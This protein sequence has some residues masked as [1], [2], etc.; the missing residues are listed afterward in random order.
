MTLDD[1][2]HRFDFFWWPLAAQPDAAWNPSFVYV[3]DVVRQLG[4]DTPAAEAAMPEYVERIN[5]H[6]FADIAPLITVDAVYWFND[7]SHTGLAATQAA[8]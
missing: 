6:N 5:S 3:L 1:G 2:G 7:G 8:F 4:V